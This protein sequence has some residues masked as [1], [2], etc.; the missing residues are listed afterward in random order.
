MSAAAQVPQSKSDSSAGFDLTSIVDCV[1][2]SGTLAVIPIGWTFQV[3]RHSYARIASRPDLA[4]GFQVGG[5]VIDSDLSPG[6]S[7]VK[8]VFINQSPEDSVVKKGD[9][10]AQI[11]L[12][13]TYNCKLVEVD[14]L[15]L[16]K[17]GVNRFD[18]AELGV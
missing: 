5:G 2:N 18:S 4:K 3:P 11:I 6:H 16:S 7:G 12:E 17:R 15:S 14:N 8:V 9:K 1:V 13:N 10:V